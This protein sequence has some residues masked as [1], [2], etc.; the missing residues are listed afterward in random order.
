MFYGR[1]AGGMPTASAVLGDLI[2]AAMNLGQKTHRPVPF[3]P[4]A[5]IRPID[6]LDSAY[7]I[8]LTVTDSPG[9]LST[10]AGVFG[11]NRVSIRAMQQEGSGDEARV[12]F[13]THVANERDVRTTLSGLGELDEVSDIHSVLRVIGQ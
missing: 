7:Y 6:Q 9:V 3:G 11:R 5:T 2:D 12:A 1:G 10:V 8:G 13:I 4:R